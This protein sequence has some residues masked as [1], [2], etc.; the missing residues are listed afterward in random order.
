MEPI[1]DATCTESLVTVTLKPGA[2]LK[3]TDMKATG[4]KTL[5][6]DGGKP[7]IVFNTLKVD[8]HVTLTLHVEK[9]P[10]KVAGALKALGFKDVTAEGDVYDCVVKTP[11]DIATVV[12]AVLQE[13]RERLQDLR[14][15]QDCV[16]HAPA[17]K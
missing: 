5:T 10:D 4:K 14:D 8:G 12:K 3:W 11:V 1:A 6:Y 16:W 15:L 17:P 7:V 9:N 2:S 13:D